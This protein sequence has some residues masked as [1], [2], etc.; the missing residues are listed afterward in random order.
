MRQLPNMLAAISLMVMFQ[1]PGQSALATTAISGSPGDTA[2]NF[3]DQPAGT[4]VTT[5]Y[6][7]LGGLGEGVTFGPLPGNAG[8]GF[9]P[10]IAAVPGGE[11]QSGTNVADISSC[12]SC[13]FAVADVTGTFGIPQQHVAVFAGAFGPASGF[14]CPPSSSSSGCAEVTL[15]AFDADGHVMAAS[16][17]AT[18]TAGAGFHTLLSVSVAAP[19]IIGFEV[20]A[21]G[22]LDASKRIGID[23]LSFGG[24]VTGLPPDFTI[25]PASSAVEL[26]QGGSASDTVSIGRINGSTGAITFAAS[27][28]PSGVTATFTP[29]P[30][31]GAQTVLTL[32]AATSASLLGPPPPLITVTATQTLNARTIQHSVTIGIYLRQLFTLGAPSQVDL[33]NCSINVPI[34]VDRGPGFS[35]PV[36]LTVSGFPAGIVDNAIFAPASLTFPAGGLAQTADLALSAPESGLPIRGVITVHATGPTGIEKTADITLTGTC[37]ARYDIRV[38]SMQVSQGTQVVKLPVRDYNQHPSETSYRSVPGA[39]E[40]VAGGETI[41]RVFANARTAPPGGVPG[42]IAELHGYST[43][44]SYGVPSPHRGAELPGSPLLPIAGPRTLQVGGDRPT[45]G[46]ETDS[47]GAFTFVL[48]VSWTFTGDAIYLQAELRQIGSGAVV[49][50][51]CAGCADDRFFQLNDVTFRAAGNTI[52][53]PIQL[54]IR[55]QPSLPPVADV[56]ADALNVIP[57]NISVAPYQATLDVS[58]IAKSYHL[59]LTSSGCSIPLYPTGAADDGANNAVANRV[60]DWDSDHY[61][62]QGFYTVGVNHCVARGNTNY[63]NYQPWSI[64]CSVDA[65]VDYERPLTSVAHELFHIFGRPHASA[66][67]GGAGETWPPDQQG[68]LQSIGI[69]RRSSPFKIFYPGLLGEPSQWYDLMSYCAY[70]GFGPPDMPPQDSWVS[71]HNWNALVNATAVS[72][73]L[74][75]SAGQASASSSDRSGLRVRANVNG[76][77]VTISS[78]QPAPSATAQ[79]GASGYRI[80]SLDAA[81]HVISEAAM[82]QSQRHVDGRAAESELVGEVPRAGVSTIQI[83]HNGA[84]VASRTRG[85]T[86]LSVAI[87]SPLPGAHLLGQTI[88]V[89]WKTHGGRHALVASVDYSANHG[90]TWKTVFIGPDDGVAIL[91]SSYLPKSG[92]GL[93]RVRVN[94]GFTEMAATSGPFVVPGTAPVVTITSPSPGYVIRNDSELYLSGQAF[95][96]SATLLGGSEMRWFQGTRF[97][98]TGSKLSVSDLVPGRTSISLSARDRFGRVATASVEINVQRADPL[99]LTLGAPVRIST[100]ATLVDLRVSSSLTGVLTVSGRGISQRTFAVNRH[101][102]VVSIPVPAGSSPVGLH[103]NLSAYS[104]NTDQN[105]EIPRIHVD[106]GSNGP[107]WWGLIVFVLLAGLCAAL[108]IRRARSS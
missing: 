56:F 61:N 66:C 7:D 60:D 68:F 69:D 88:T 84:V 1:V 108:A 11:A 43:A 107:L 64:A 22:S 23:D 46:E 52:I 38:T 37:A 8:T 70:A 32:T 93:L 51:E 78:M 90:L 24:S 97:L 72:Y 31:P 65:V 10:V 106:E 19:A 20:S 35:G 73:A 3:D 39:A 2:V 54:T 100:A 67:K 17:P 58:D 77:S 57:I 6:A 86:R 48:P 14:P 40:L 18:L 85:Q 26:G 41:V 80:R 87:T 79:S 98:G 45:L 83:L 33:S 25:A 16:T 76:R 4:L 5:H 81:G 13:E 71:V 102:H 34:T 42:V 62:G 49:M 104:G 99:F 50:R 75:I 82:V 91:P 47:A 15:R 74:R 53:H 44:R 96:D 103:L 94:D 21:R 30:A 36:V 89:R 63:C 59:N 27:G 12:S 92:A 29:D 105:L 28:L 9:T 95:D 101:L 55:G